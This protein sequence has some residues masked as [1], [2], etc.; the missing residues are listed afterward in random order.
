MFKTILNKIK[1]A[2]KAE[3]DRLNK[4]WG[5]DG[6]DHARYDEAESKAKFEEF[7]RQSALKVDYTISLNNARYLRGHIAVS[8]SNLVNKKT[9]TAKAS[10]LKQIAWL[11][12]KLEEELANVNHFKSLLM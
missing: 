6:S 10:A 12:S 4:E 9:K 3:G 8:T 11:E 7:T 5:L 1:G 2:I